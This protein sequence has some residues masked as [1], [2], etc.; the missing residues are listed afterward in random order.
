M[1]S[2]APSA[3]L[4]LLCALAPNALAGSFA[5][6]SAGTSAGASSAGTSASSNSTSG[7][8]KLVREARE[9]AAG[10]VASEGQVRTARLE[11]ALRVMRERDAA[12]R[13]ASDLALARAI[14]A[15]E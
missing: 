3:A 1:K 2:F 4:V 5:G 9:D 10:F 14:L 11:A 6:T 13:E 7:D 15:R 8:D 12:A